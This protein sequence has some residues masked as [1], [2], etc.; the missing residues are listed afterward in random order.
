MKKRRYLCERYENK[1]FKIFYLFKGL[2]GYKYMHI[3]SRISF[4]TYLSNQRKCFD[5]ISTFSRWE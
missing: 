4:L 1:V 5:T 2:S 3:L